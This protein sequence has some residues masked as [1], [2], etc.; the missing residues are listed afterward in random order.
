SGSRKLTRPAHL[1]QAQPGNQSRLSPDRALLHREP[2]GKTV[3][4]SDAAPGA[5]AGSDTIMG[6]YDRD[7]YRREGPSFLGSLAEQGRVTNWLVGI[8][9]A[10]FIVQ[11]ATR[12]VGFDE[13]GLREV[14]QPFTDALLL[15]VPLVLKGEVWRLLT[16]AFLH[17]PNTIWHIVFNMLVLF[18]F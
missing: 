16:Y 8:N 11:V 7:Y 5:P 1:P 4:G 6:I 13:F 9:I 17:D 10:C 2:C 18:W 12:T 15:D 3:V 14:K